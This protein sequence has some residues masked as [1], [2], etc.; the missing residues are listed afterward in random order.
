[1]FTFQP[2][3]MNGIP[4][5]PPLPMNSPGAVCCKGP[6]RPLLRVTTLTTSGLVRTRI[7]IL[8]CGVSCLSFKSTSRIAGPS[9]AAEGFGEGLTRYLYTG[10][11]VGLGNAL[12]VALGDALGCG[13]TDSPGAGVTGGDADGDG[14]GV[15]GV[16]CQR[17]SPAT[18]SAPAT[19]PAKARQR[20]AR[21]RRNAAVTAPPP[22]HGAAQRAA[23]AAPRGRRAERVRAQ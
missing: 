2:R 6:S 7:A 10:V 12:G 20:P 1:M 3:A 9:L 16:A 8:P 23:T 13:T 18:G 14:C 22:L 15:A 11:A 17:S 21:P 5:M 4:G 19:G